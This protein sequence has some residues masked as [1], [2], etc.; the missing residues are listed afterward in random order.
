ME[1][2]L[3]ALGA[4]IVATIIC[5]SLDVIRINHQLNRIINYDMSLF[6]RGIKYGIIV[7]PSFWIIYFPVYKRLK[8]YKIN[9]SISAY[10]A[11]CL[12]STITTPFWILRQKAQINEVHVWKS[13]YSNYYKGL[14]STYII[15]L[16]FTVHIPL[17]EYLKSKTDNSTFNT[18]IN[19]AISKTI[20]S[21]IFYPF[22]TIRA[23]LR[24]NKPINGIKLF[25]FY[26]G[27]PIY[28]FRSVPYYTSVFCTFEFIKNKI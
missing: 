14:P 7:V 13:P 15:N 21:C 4:G 9:T 10:V 6:Y 20:A 18:S 5:N 26:R 17:Y 25:D 2:I 1:E 12:A 16:S 22:D 3:P 27:M 24:D 28:I 23:R 19:T 11:C 8:D